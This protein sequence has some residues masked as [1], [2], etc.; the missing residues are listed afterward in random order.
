MT[1]VHG[2]VVGDKVLVPRSELEHLVTVAER[3]E[4]VQLHLQEQDMPST[5][6]LRLL[7]ARGSFAFW[8]EDGEGVYPADDGEPV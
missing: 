1:T 5:G 6:W 7:E 2:Q 3:S 4:P 8:Q